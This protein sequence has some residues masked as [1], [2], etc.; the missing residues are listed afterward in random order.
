MP[1]NAFKDS[2]AVD[3]DT[4]DGDSTKALSTIAY[5]KEIQDTTVDSP[6]EST[7]SPQTGQKTYRKG[8]YSGSDTIK[9]RIVNNTEKII[10]IKKE[11]FDIKKGENDV[12]KWNFQ[13]VIDKCNRM[14][15]ETDNDDERYFAEKL[16]DEIQFIQSAITILN[17]PVKK[18]K[19]GNIHLEKSD[20]EYIAV[21]WV[22]GQG[23]YLGKPGTHVL[24]KGNKVIYYLKDQGTALSACV[25]KRIAIKRGSIVDLPPKFGCKL[26]HV[27]AL[28]ILSE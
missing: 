18:V 5:K 21:G 17:P 14:L 11:Y 25:N 26:I 20:K 7:L 28:D 4:T 15:A 22:T 3:S 19:P 6:E 8:K 1:L 24:M 27:Q 9:Q 23:K 2:P 10:R 12:E 13:P 16:L